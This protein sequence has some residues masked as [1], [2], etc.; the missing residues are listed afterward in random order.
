MLMLLS[1]YFN[2]IFLSFVLREKYPDIE[3]V[4]YIDEIEGYLQK[5]QPVLNLM[6]ILNNLFSFYFR[7]IF[8]Y[9]M[10]LIQI[11]DCH[12]HYQILIF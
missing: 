1:N 4:I 7:K 2:L 10:E 11:Q 3:N 12:L 5:N 6:I 9:I 8:F